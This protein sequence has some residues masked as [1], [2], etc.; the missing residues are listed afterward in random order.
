MQVGGV[1]F[2]VVD[3]CAVVGVGSEVA[4]CSVEGT[5]VVQT[6]VTV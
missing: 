3:G 6:S 2:G 1:S 4:G 5:S